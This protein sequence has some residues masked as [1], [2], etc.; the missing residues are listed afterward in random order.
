MCGI[1]DSSEKM[2]DVC[3][4]VVLGPDP[5]SVIRE[6]AA[7]DG[8]NMPCIM[9]KFGKP[10]TVVPKYAVGPPWA[11]LYSLSVPLVPCTF[12]G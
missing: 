5:V 3:P 10:G 11:S 12:K 6:N 2:T 1:C 4:V 7:I 8:N 9:K